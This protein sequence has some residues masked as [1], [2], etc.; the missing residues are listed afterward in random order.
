MPGSPEQFGD[1]IR[2]EIARIGKIARTAGI[3][4]E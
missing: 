2:S 3:K 4:A 1:H